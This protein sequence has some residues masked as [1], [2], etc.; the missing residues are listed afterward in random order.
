MEKNKGGTKGGKREIRMKG[1][2]REK[3]TE[4]KK[5]RERQGEGKEWRE[6]EGEEREERREEK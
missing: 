6:R 4:R 2:K 1:E 5:Q 3:E